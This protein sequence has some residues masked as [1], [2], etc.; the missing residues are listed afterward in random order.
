MADNYM[1]CGGPWAGTS[2]NGG[3][4]VENWMW[5]PT[6]GFAPTLA[7]VESDQDI[8][9]SYNDGGI[10]GLDVVQ[11]SYQWSDG[12]R[13]NG[14]VIEYEYTNNGSVA[15]ISSLFASLQLDA[16]IVN[17]WWGDD[18]IAYSPG[19][20]VLYMYD[21]GVDCS[22]PDFGIPCPEGYIGI[23]VIAD[24]AG[25]P[26][27]TVAPHTATWNFYDKDLFQA[28]RE[29]INPA[30]TS[31]TPVDGADYRMLLTAMPFPLASGASQKVTFALVMG[32]SPE[33]LDANAAAIADAYATFVTGV[34]HVVG[35]EIPADY[36]LDQNYPNPFNPATTFSFAL[37]KASRA[38]LR[39][40]N[41]LG[42]EV[43]TLL[44]GDLVAGVHDVKWDATGMPSG[45]YLYR[46]EAEGYSATKRMVLLK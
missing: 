1:C 40:F 5:Q 30:L 2:L 44:S 19:S 24:A 22:N 46:L 21:S 23:A 37:P 32:T 12:P 18:L 20:R 39:I 17:G 6:P 41:V 42:Q 36:R 31:G 35:S 16:D 8:T 29:G 38:T 43:A 3:T 26:G 9:V 27:S 7:S 14:I 13:S 10:L 28:M 33:E 45:L 4:V 15:D 25:S 34:E 11:R